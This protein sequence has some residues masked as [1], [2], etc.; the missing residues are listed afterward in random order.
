M[1]E[2][3]IRRETG[4]SSPHRQR[5]TLF[6]KESRTLADA[7]KTLGILA[8]VTL[9]SAAF[10]FLGLTEATIVVMYVLGV[11]LTAIA[12]PK[13]AYCFL[14]SALSVLA[15][16]FF[17]ATPRYSLEAWGAE[18]PATFVVM[19]VVAFVASWLTMQLRE[20]AS[21]EAM[22]SRRTQVLLDCE[23]LLQRCRTSDD[24]ARVM[25]R[26]L[27]ELL[28]DDV[29]WFPATQGG[30][31][32]GRTLRATDP[33]EAVPVTAL[34]PD[35]AQLLLSQN[36]D[37]TRDVSGHLD[38][39][40][41]YL[42]VRSADALFG[43]VAVHVGDAGVRPEER[44][45]A[46]SVVGEA[47]LALERARALTE[48]EEAA[49]LA[50]NEQLR[51]NLLR[52]ISHDLRTP[53]T[54]ISGNADVLLSEGASLDPASARQLLS[55]VYDDAQWLEALVENLLAATRLEDGTVRLSLSY[56]TVDDLVEEALRHVGRATE[57]HPLSVVGSPDVLLVRVDAQLIVQVIVNL[58]NN[59][60][61]HTPA[62]SHVIISSGRD[63]DL[64][65][66]S[67]ADD[68][69][70]IP[71]ADKDHVFES[72]STAG[73]ARSDGQRSVGLGLSL[74]RS[75]VEAHGGAISLVDNRPHGCVFSFTLSLE[76]MPQDAQ[77]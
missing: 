24:I 47:A 37:V 29:T 3:P 68:G 42:P 71:D 33:E 77:D 74:C 11:L 62:G 55:D 57:T 56:E 40:A 32:R 61:A 63:G 58:V 20:R 41:L 4:A 5:W 10:E 27:V 26:Q 43:V 6:P 18:Y 16:N 52:S 64:V 13:R 53:L 25:C 46:S 21:A 35:A 54:T 59:A 70:G 66:V 44:T 39:Y 69:P 31:A 72:F 14:A 22:A 76:E 8:A 28:G 17:F 75:I 15:F 19:F 49:I 45:I 7:A 50:R 60:L 48:R 1:Q 23:R 12:T 38:N 34:P 2:A 67:V 36:A 30:L 65:R 9:V 51:A 73:H